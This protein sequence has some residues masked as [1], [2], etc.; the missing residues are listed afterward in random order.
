MLLTKKPLFENYLCKLPLAPSLFV[1][2]KAAKLRRIAAPRHIIATSEDHLA[3]AG[4]TNG[5]KNDYSD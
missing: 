4:G 5:E 3:L 2:H 1:P